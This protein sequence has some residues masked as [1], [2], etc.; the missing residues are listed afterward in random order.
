MEGEAPV[1]CG[2]CMASWLE[3]I[4]VY[5]VFILGDPKGIRTKHIFKRILK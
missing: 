4:G 3:L 5:T 1:G 2:L